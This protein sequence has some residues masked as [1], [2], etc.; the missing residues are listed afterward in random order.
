MKTKYF[1]I[2]VMSIALVMNASA[3]SKPI[4]LSQKIDSIISIQ[5]NDG[6]PGGVIGVISGGDVVVKKCFG[7]MDAENNKANTET[8]LFD[9]AS[10][11]KQFTAFSILL[12]ELEGKLN[13]DE[14]IRY[15][16]PYLP[17]YEYEITARHLLQ[18]TS[19]IASTDWLRLL[20][21]IPFDAEWTQKDEIDIIQ[22]YSKLNFKPNTKHVYSNAGY[23]LLAQ[24]V[25]SVSGMKFP[26]FVD[27]KIFTPLGM[28]TAII[29][30]NSE[31]EQVNTAL[32]YDI[33]EDKPVVVSSTE[34]Y[35][36]GGGNIFA[37]LND[38][39]NWGQNFFSPLVGN[40][41]I[42]HRIRNKYN[43]LEN[44]DSI[45]YTY[46]FYVAKHKGLRIVSHS[47]G[48]PGFRS[49][50]IMFP[51][52]GLFVVVMLNNEKINS[53]KLALDIVGLLLADKMIEDAPVPKVE[54]TLDLEEIKA[55]QG[56]Y[57]MPDG[58]E[59][60]FELI[61]NEFWLLLPGD[62]KFQLFAESDKKFFLKDF[63]AQA[64]FVVGEN[65]EVNEMIWHQ[66]GT[67]YHAFRVEE[68]FPL[69]IEEIASFA[70]EYYH[71]DLNTDYNIIFEDEQLK[72][73]PP[74]TFE[75]YFRSALIPL[76]HVNGDRFATDRFGM[77]EF[78]RNSDN[79]IIG[80][81]MLDIG[82]VQNVKFV[83]K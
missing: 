41:D 61:E 66:G 59:M 36:Y 51:D 4:N 73:I 5:H 40:E 13:L 52:E 12:L 67:D 70:G 35:C 57:Q 53:R 31:I 20:S 39:M 49:Q 7:I 79:E 43:T 69:T 71:Q 10:V 68:T 81:V 82:R 80:F 72:I 42:M 63:N 1:L 38:M 29:F 19:G 54:M 77:V 46:G 37:S 32:G 50:V 33:I 76:N 2:A 18:H 60:G 83:R 26:E 48:L 25:E 17:D 15:Y 58:M 56:Y 65:G 47:G 11:A 74:A 78:T 24:I 9:I 14:N 75:R 55:Y 62:Q 3:V 23:A 64:T 45:S 28:K 34:D 27:E 44:G 30:H 8:T 21:N 16:L 6:Q 22:K